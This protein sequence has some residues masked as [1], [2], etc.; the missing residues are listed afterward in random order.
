MVWEQSAD[1]QED[2]M[3]LSENFLGEFDFEMVS[4]RKTLERIPEDKLAW[5]PHDKSTSLGRLAGHI[6]EL[7]SMG[8]RVM[9]SEMFDLANRPPNAKPLVAESQKHVLEIFDKNVADLRAAL[10]GASDADLQKNWTLALG[11]KKFYS[12][13][14]IGALRRMMLNHMIHHRAQLGV[15]LRLND[16]AVPSVYGPSADEGR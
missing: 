2:R 8:G 11:D 13:P 12:G 16:V 6:A 3:G 4:T 10:A 14:R 9:Q 15:Y 7:P 5:K 1:L